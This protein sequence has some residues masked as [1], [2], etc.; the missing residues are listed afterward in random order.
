MHG[1]SRRTRQAGRWSPAFIPIL[2]F[3]LAACGAVTATPP[4]PV[5]LRAAGSTSMEPL[6]V[7][8][9]AAY[10]TQQPQ[11]IVDVQGGGSQLGQRWV[12]SGQVELGLVS[13]PPPRLAEGQQL[14]PV[15]REAIA[16]IT[17]PQNRSVALSRAELRDIFSGRLLNWQEV[18]GPAGFIQVIS[19]EDGSGTRAAFETMVMEGQAVT[20]M[21][22]VLPNSQVVVDYVANHPEAVGYVSLALADDRV[23]ALSIE[24]SLPSREALASGSYPLARDLAVLVRQPATPAVNQFLEF[25]LSPAGQTIVETRWIRVK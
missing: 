19:R 15:A 6:L 2:A 4:S 16:I 1:W 25:I 3:L 14:I 13:W 5:F 22:M 8:L 9:A 21:A 18:D 20:P 12:E 7:E 11:V 24:G 23:T 10:A 17:H